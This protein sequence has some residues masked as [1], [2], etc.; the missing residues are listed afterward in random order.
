MEIIF[1]VIGVGFLT[2]V[3]VLILKP[4]KPDIAMLLGL[5]GGIIVFFYIIDLI[6]QVFGLFEYIMDKTNLD[7]KL[8]TILIKIVGVGYLTE[9]SSNVC[10][11][12]GNSSMAGK[13]QL[14]GKLIIFV[15]S[16]P[17]I[18]SLVELIVSIMP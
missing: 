7:S 2:V 12:S 15:M 8:F 16:I 4:T 14:A 1:K 3:G 10:L 6:E 18:S 17:I 11:D 13:L 5:C 9:F